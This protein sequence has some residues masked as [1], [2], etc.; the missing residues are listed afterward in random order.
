MF[1]NQM[2]NVMK[3]LEMS[4]LETNEWN[5]HGQDGAQT[6]DC[7][8][9]HIDA[10]RKSACQHQNQDVKGDEVDEEHIAS[11]GRYLRERE[12]KKKKGNEQTYL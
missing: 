9:G 1:Q 4:Y 12:R 6:V 10:V 3:T 2:L 7:A 5:L 11:P 8:V